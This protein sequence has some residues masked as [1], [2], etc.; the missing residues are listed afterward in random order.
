MVSVVDAINSLLLFAKTGS[1][2]RPQMDCRAKMAPST[3][4]LLPMHSSSQ[5]RRVMP[6]S[7]GKRDGSGRKGG[8]GG[9]A[10]GA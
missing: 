4:C 5:M 2:R 3:C 7:A 6:R 10:A 1:G 9:A 8:R